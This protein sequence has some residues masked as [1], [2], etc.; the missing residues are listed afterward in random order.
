MNEARLRPVLANNAYTSGSR[1]K[2]LAT[3]REDES[4]DQELST[5]NSVSKLSIKADG[6]E[7]GDSF[8]EEAVPSDPL[9]PLSSFGDEG[10]LS[11]YFLPQNRIGK[12]A[13]CRLKNLGEDAERFSQETGIPV[14]ELSKEELETLFPKLRSIS[15]DTKLARSRSVVIG[16][17]QSFEKDL[18]AHL[19]AIVAQNGPQSLYEY[20]YEKGSH[21]VLVYER[22]GTEPRSLLQII[23]SDEPPQL[24]DTGEVDSTKVI[25]QVEVSYQFWLS[26][27]SRYLKFSIS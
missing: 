11:R 3:I 8:E 4:N 14:H 26:Q 27:I 12:V 18:P 16:N 5:I 9:S 15:E 7:L 20:E 23:S 6:T 1:R 21:K 17:S 10:S 19:Q 25:L 22:F 2:E 24:T 13:C